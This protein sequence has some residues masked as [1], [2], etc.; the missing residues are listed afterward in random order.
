MAIHHK[1]IS[2]KVDSQDTSLINPSNWNDDHKFET[3]S[4]LVGA[5]GVLIG[6]DVSGSLDIIGVS[7]T[8]GNQ[9]LKSKN[10]N[11][12]Y[13]FA[14]NVGG[15]ILTTNDFDWSQVIDT[16]IPAGINVITLTPV[17]EGL[18]GFDTNH[19]VTIEN[20][21][22]ATSKQLASA[23]NELSGTPIK[24]RTQTPHGYQTGNLVVISG[25]SNNYCNGA[26]VIQVLDS[27]TFTL[28][29]SNS[30]LFVFTTSGNGVSPIVVTISPTSSDH[31]YQ[32]GDTVTVQGVGGNTNANGT[33]TITRIDNR[34]FSL[35]GT[36]GNGDFT[37]TGNS[38]VTGQ[39]TNTGALVV[40]GAEAVLISGGTATS[41]AAS[42]TIIVTTSNSHPTGFT[43]RSATAGTME[44][45]NK[46]FTQNKKA[47]HIPNGNY[48]WQQ[49]VIL[50]SNFCLSGS[51]DGTRI[52]LQPLF[53]GI[54]VIKTQGTTGAFATVQSNLPAANRSFP[55]L[56]TIAVN[57]TANFH[58]DDCVK[59][60]CSDS[61]GNFFYQVNHVKN[62]SGLSMQLKSM[63]LIPLDPSQSGNITQIIPTTNVTI[64][65]LIID[66]GVASGN[67]QVG[68]LSYYGIY[69]NLSNFI[70]I[71]NI[72]FHNF[73]R[74]SS[75]TLSEG[76]GNVVENIQS[77]N[78]GSFQVND[79]AYYYQTNFKSSDI[80][81]RNCPSFGLG[82]YCCI[83][84]QGIN[85]T[86]DRSASRLLKIHS[87][88][89]SSFTNIFLA[90]SE[91]GSG[92]ALTGGS[93]RCCLTNVQAYNIKVAEGGLWM[94]GT[95]EQY[96]IIDGLQVTGSINGVLIYPTAHHNSVR[97]IHSNKPIIDWSTEGTIS[98]AQSYR[99]KVSK[100]DVQLIPSGVQTPIGWNSIIY[101]NGGL[102]DPGSQT[103]FTIPNNISG[104]ESVEYTPSLQIMGRI[105]TITAQVGYYPNTVGQRQVSIVKNRGRATENI[106]GYALLSANQ[107]V[108]ARTV[109][110]VTC[111]EMLFIGDTIEV[112]A[113]QSSGADLQIVEF[114]FSTFS[115][116]VHD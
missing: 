40:S 99:A 75:I 8:A 44:A 97:N 69:C 36:T 23:T 33:R 35:N 79:Q 72:R 60:T 70:T 101:N 34:K 19:W 109:M 94:A 39:Y 17:P 105:C 53:P 81:I 14:A 7:S 31:G 20:P 37:Y 100:G 27:T 48:L 55:L 42:G 10:D 50:P 56:D 78:G 116:I 73:A 43:I 111:D 86:V 54:Q 26:F 25:S 45:I 85:L 96:N 67:G 21:T 13:E 76:Y 28:T 2:N 66:A 74:T 38:Y 62:I 108:G 82:Y 102:F 106:I 71:K 95:D 3:P 1:F 9:Y 65:D 83:D 24:I 61:F 93:Y 22:A 68:S 88:G 15:D 91:V 84:A 57:A 41:G 18:N 52:T 30:Q 87:T 80:S 92:A 114:G 12:G 58:V 112:I 5:E 46:A 47:V 104:D 77:D 64:R 51:P 115:I 6:K 103:K 110:T 113:F 107:A 49:G 59:L 4:G 16:A 90:N 11:S 63:V 89:F 29:G 32:T 98:T